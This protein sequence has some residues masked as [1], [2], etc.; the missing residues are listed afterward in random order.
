MKQKSTTRD[1]SK[2]GMSP[3]R[4]LVFTLCSL[5]FLPLLSG[6]LVGS[7]S[8]TFMYANG[9]SYFSD[10]PRSCAN[11]HVMQ[12]HLSAWQKS[13]HHAFATCNDCHTPHDSLISKLLVKGINGFNHS[14]KFTTGDYPDV[15]LINE[16]NTKVTEAACRHCHSDLTGSIE[17]AHSRSESVSCL[18]CHHEV[19]HLE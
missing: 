6:A 7:G 3:R 4:G 8:Y 10:D 2:T 13:S 17:P 14:L 16:M 19:G 5:L 12:D 1:R 11:C 18:R 9:G 15:L